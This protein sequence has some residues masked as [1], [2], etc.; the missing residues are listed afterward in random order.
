MG[1]FSKAPLN[2]PSNA[3]YATQMPYSSVPAIPGA[4]TMHYGYPAPQP[5]PG[6]YPPPP[7]QGLGYAQ[8]GY[9]NYPAMPPP[10]MAVP[11]MPQSQMKAL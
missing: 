5:P 8:P 11:M 1:T 2:A 3:N 7:P 4:S 6:P 9:Y 10:P